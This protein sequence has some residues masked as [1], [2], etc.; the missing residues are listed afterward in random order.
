MCMRKLKCKVL[1]LEKN[2]FEINRHYTDKIEKCQQ[3]L[4]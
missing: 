1:E 3:T 4:N 2:T